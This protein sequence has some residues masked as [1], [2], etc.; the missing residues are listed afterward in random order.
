[1]KGK[2]TDAR[3]EYW[4]FRDVENHFNNIQAGIRNRAATW[5]LAAYTAIAVLLKISSEQSWLIPPT[6]L[7]GIV[8][9]MATFG[10]LV[11]WINEQLVYQR[12]LD[13]GF[14]IAMKQEVDNKSLPP[15]RLMQ[16]HSSEGSGMSRWMVF[17]YTIPMLS[18]LLISVIVTVLNL[19][20]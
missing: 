20:I 2:T 4:Q 1:M 8:S 14:V 16:M 18:F 3:E 19:S 7:I 10:I 12:L 9:L 13:A 11:H 17:Y 6:V 15:L 5:L